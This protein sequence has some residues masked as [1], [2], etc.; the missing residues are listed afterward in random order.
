MSYTDGLT[1]AEGL[2][3]YTHSPFWCS[4][5]SL[6]MCHL[7]PWLH[8]TLPHPCD[9][10]RARSRTLPF[11]PS[12]SNLKRKII[13]RGRSNKIQA[14]WLVFDNRPCSSLVLPLPGII[15][16]ISH[17]PNL[18]GCGGHFH[19]LSSSSFKEIL[20]VL[21]ARG[22]DGDNPQLSAS[23]GTASAAESQPDPKVVSLVLSEV[24]H[25]QCSRRKYKLPAILAQ[26]RTTLKDH[27]SSRAPCG[28]AEA[29]V[30]PASQLGFS[31][32]SFLLPS[33]PFPKKGI[34]RVHPN[35]HPTL[36][37]LSQSQLPR[38]PSLKY[39]V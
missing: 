13:L 27:S 33:P 11:C 26:L 35:K 1:L 24:V 19:A 36:Y 9:G 12:L 10:P 15:T 38:K 4:V 20:V 8:C 30:G 5:G 39:K 21:A 29:I 14:A 17:S 22:P 3:W 31:F 16:Q 32:C 34:P 25:I 23:S 18:T 28:S 37:A 6:S 7:H 2:R